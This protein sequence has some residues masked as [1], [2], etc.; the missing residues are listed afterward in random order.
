VLGD[1]AL[2]YGREN[3]FEAYYTA[4]VWHGIFTGPDLQGIVNPGFNRARG[5]AIVTSL[6]VHLEF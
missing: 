3:V 5:P 4:H 6:R 1:G 2:H